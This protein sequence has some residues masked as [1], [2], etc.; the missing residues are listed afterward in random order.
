[1]CD[2]A[3]CSIERKGPTSLPLGLITPIVPATIK[4][5][6]F[7]VNAKARPAAAIRVAPMTSMRRRPIRSACVVSNRETTTSP[8]S[9]S[10]STRPLC[11]SVSPSPTR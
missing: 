8:A 4:K 3:A 6:R 7:R 5:N 10:V 11:A 1:M 2:R 9:V